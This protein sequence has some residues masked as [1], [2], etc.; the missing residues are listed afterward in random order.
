MDFGNSQRICDNIGNIINLTESTF[1]GD[2]C[3]V[4][5]LLKDT[6]ETENLLVL[7]NPV[8]TV[9]PNSC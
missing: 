9:Q 7:L 6:K 2:L 1:S 8:A 5:T 4:L 3:K